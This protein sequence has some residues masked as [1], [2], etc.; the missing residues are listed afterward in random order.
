LVKADAADFCGTEKP[1]IAGRNRDMVEA[2]I[3]QLA[4]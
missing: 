4:K 3:D 1:S 2:F